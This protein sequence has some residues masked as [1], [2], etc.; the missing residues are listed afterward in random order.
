MH[1]KIHVFFR[2]LCFYF[3]AFFLFRLGVDYIW[4]SQA[5]AGA[6]ILCVTQTLKLAGGTL[7]GIPEHCPQQSV[8]LNI[9]NFPVSF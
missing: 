9:T 7:R 8:P 3:S 5:F 2:I 6:A 1:V 4:R